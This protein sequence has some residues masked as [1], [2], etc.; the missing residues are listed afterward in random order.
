MYNVKCIQYMMARECF[1]NWNRIYKT[2]LFYTGFSSKGENSDR[3]KWR[4]NQSCPLQI[5]NISYTHQNSY[6]L[7]LD[8]RC[9]CNWTHIR[10]RLQHPVIC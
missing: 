5:T 3:K 2:T 6:D 8:K 10:M 1:N 9:T 4:K 7:T